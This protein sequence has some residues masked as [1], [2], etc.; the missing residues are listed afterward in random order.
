MEALWIWSLEGAALYHTWGL[1]LLYYVKYVWIF[2][3]TANEIVFDKSTNLTTAKEEAAKLA[4]HKICDTKS[5]FSSKIA[6]I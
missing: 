5:V 3:Y 1:K 2:S 4:H 6:L